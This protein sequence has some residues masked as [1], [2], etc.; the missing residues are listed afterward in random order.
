MNTDERD[1]AVDAVDTANDQ[2]PATTKQR[3]DVV[4][5]IDDSPS[6]ATAL[7]WAADYV[8]TN[9]LPLR[10][11][12]AWQLSAAASAAVA[13]GDA[14]YFEAV[15]ADARARATRFVLDVLGGGAAEIRWTLDIG[16]GGAGPVLVDRSRGAQLLVVGTR[17]HTGL[18]RAVSGSVSHYCVSHAEVPV[19]AVPSSDARHTSGGTRQMASPAPLL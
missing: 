5:G 6:A 17:E 9:G 14:E 2:E 15:G 18:R 13:A 8:H 11:V 3:N 16:E 12:H 10:V 7:L 1:I 4:V 19:L